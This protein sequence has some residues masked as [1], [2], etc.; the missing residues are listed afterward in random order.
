ML[1]WRILLLAGP[2]ASFAAANA[3]SDDAPAATQ[4]IE[5]GTFDGPGPEGICPASPPRTGELCLVPEGTTCAFAACGTAIATCHRGVWAYAGNPPPR[6]SCDPNPP[7]SE[8]ACPP[9][10]P[11][12]V[13]CRYG[14]EDCSDPDAS[15]NRTVASCPS[16]T[17]VLEFFPCNDAGTDVQRDAARDAD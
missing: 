11:P 17:W 10:W 13:S 9:C 3:C 4:T 15:A 1:R 5:A 16:G 6:P 2:V 7:A 8:S 12:E 14:S